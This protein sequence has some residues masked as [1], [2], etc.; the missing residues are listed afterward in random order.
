MTTPEAGC[1]RLLR[2]IEALEKLAE[3]H[4]RAPC[5]MYW[6]VRPI[7][8]A[9]LSEARCLAQQEPVATDA[10]RDSAYAKIDRFLR[11]NLGDMDYTEYSE[12]L[13]VL[14]A[15]PP[16]EKAALLPTETME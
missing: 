3:M 1:P 10:E 14:Y 15:S 4:K 12:T 13:D 8:E 16:T 6:D 11:N 2:I 7:A 9:A 5:S